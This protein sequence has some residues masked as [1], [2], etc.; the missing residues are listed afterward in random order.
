MA[1]IIRRQLPPQY[2]D[3][4][5]YK[6]FLR[7]DFRWRCCYCTI[8]EANWG[9]AGH[10][11]VE[12]FR[13]KDKFENLSTVY[14]NLYYACDLCN[15]Y[16]WNKWPN[17]D[18]TA[19]GRRFFDPCSDL[20]S[21]HFV[22]E[23]LGVLK[24]LTPCGEYTWKS[25]RLNR[26]DLIKMRNLRRQ[27]N[28]KFRQVLKDIRELRARQSLLTLGPDADLL[29]RIIDNEIFCY[30][31]SERAI[32]D[33]QFRLKRLFSFGSARS[34]ARG[35]LDQEWKHRYQPRVCSMWASS[36]AATARPF[37]APVRSSLTSSNT[38]G[39]L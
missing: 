9:N 35:T 30:N 18:D 17:D 14:S 23:G 27:L 20:S 8:H 11:A 5:S 28:S 21:A 10:F 16:K 39:S 29:E 7:L 34:F 12:H 3:Y 4:K 26:P 1:R 38:F 15:S 32:F 31:R 24:G 13:P 22:D 6:P 33:R 37:I 25:I 2:D 19:A 36:S